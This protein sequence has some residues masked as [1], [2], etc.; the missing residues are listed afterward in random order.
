MKTSMLDGFNES[1]GVIGQ[2][3]DEGSDRRE[4]LQTQSLSGRNDRD[5]GFDNALHQQQQPLTFRGA[6]T[7]P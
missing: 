4:I 2:G 7:T 6:E 5:L 3:E 1:D